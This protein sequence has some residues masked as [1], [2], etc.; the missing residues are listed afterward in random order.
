MSEYTPGDAR[1]LYY[2]LCNALKHL[3][4]TIGCI[5]DARLFADGEAYE[6]IYK[7]WAELNSARRYLHD[8]IDEALDL[9]SS[10]NEL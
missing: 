10:R 7:V 2:G 3:N 5:N 1:S 9:A 8:E 6:A 4:A